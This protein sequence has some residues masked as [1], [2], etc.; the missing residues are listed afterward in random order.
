MIIEKTTSLKTQYINL[1]PV[2]SKTS[3]L[4]TKKTIKENRG[5]RQFLCINIPYAS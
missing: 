1:S 4:Q 2:T 3:I 5:C